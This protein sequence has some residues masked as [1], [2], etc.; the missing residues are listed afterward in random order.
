M[1]CSRKI[2]IEYLCNTWTAVL[3]LGIYAI[4]EFLVFVQYSRWVFVQ[5]LGLDIYA[6]SKF[7]YVCNTQDEHLCNTRVWKFV[8]YL[9]FECFLNYFRKA[10]ELRKSLNTFFVPLLCSMSQIYPSTFNWTYWISLLSKFDLLR[11]LVKIFYT[12][13]VK[14]PAWSDRWNILILT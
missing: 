4:Y 14:D 10:S 1:H 12:C 2:K 3:G 7:R 13:G 11:L 9:G 6:I 8:Q 5:H